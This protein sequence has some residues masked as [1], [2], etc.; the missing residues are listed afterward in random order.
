M[1][2][3]T[4]RNRIF[5][6]SLAMKRF[7]AGALAESLAKVSDSQIDSD[8]KKSC[9]TRSDLFRPSHAVAY[10]RMRLASMLAVWQID[11][12]RAAEEHWHDLKIADERCRE[13]Q[14]TSRCINW[15]EFGQFN[16]APMIF[17]TNSALWSAIASVQSG[18]CATQVVS[19][20][21]AQN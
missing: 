19:D 16:T 3:W 14:N 4:I 1:K 17:C 9:L 7:R 15:L 11:V 13:C 6:I 21:E 12:E 20:A 2:P 18:S 8:L 5:A 10:H